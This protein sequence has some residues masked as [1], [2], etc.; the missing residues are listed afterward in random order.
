MQN[1]QSKSRLNLNS[2]EWVLL[3]GLMA[4]TITNGMNHHMFS[5]ALPTIRADFG[6]AAD[7]AAWVA[8]VY[9]LPFMALMPLYGRLADGL[10]KKRLLLLGMAT[11]ILGTLIVLLS[12]S[13]AMLSVGRMI[14]GIGGAG[15]NVLCIAIIAQLF[16][17]K[18]RGKMMGTWNSAMPLIGFVAPFF[19]GL[20]I[21]SYGWRAIFPFVL[22]AGLLAYWLIQRNLPE[23]PGNAPPSFLQSFDWVGVTSLTVAVILFFFFTTSRPITGVES[24]QDI[25]LFAAFAILFGSFVLWEMRHPRPYV[26]LRIF[27]KRTFTLASVIAG[28]RM[29]LMNGV[30]FLIPLYLTDLGN[31]SASTKGLML[32]LQAGALFLTSRLG[33]TLADRWGSRRPVLLSM[34]GQVLFMGMMA[35]LPANTPLWVIGIAVTFQGL[36]IGLSLAALHRGA[37]EGIAES[38]TGT[39]AG[40]YSMIRFAGIVLGTALAG[41][42]LQ[43]GLEEGGLVLDAYQMVYKMFALVAILGV[44]LAWLP[45]GEGRDR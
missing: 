43:M 6:L 39:A 33:G 27:R 42:M 16:T 13:L 9:T 15:L 28:L 37:M 40:L 29:F 25:R 12:P 32:A 41:V 18:E 30:S 14:Q 20:L 34:V 36:T 5:V 8:M 19:A 4:P 24:L 31:Y 23:L 11:S 21:D 1:V 45:Q 3:I 35:Y 22:I 44:G 7:T 38:E 17:N 2:P 26:N 10:G